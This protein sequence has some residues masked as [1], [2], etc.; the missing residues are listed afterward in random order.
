MLQDVL[1]AV[2]AIEVTNGTKLLGGGF[3]TCLQ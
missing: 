3:S 2:F 1:M